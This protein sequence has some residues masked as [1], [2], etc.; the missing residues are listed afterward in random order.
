MPHNPPIKLKELKERGML[1]EEKFFSDLAQEAGV[2]DIEIAQRVYLGLIRLIT[3]RLVESF[4][5]RL[6][7]LGDMAVPLFKARTG[8]VGN[9][10][11]KI[12]PRRT[13]K[14]Y[15]KPDWQKHIAA[16]FGYTDY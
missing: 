12:P 16:K 9:K 1:D 2:H 5:T 10:T 15:P 7:H 6:P 11:V 8:R 13:I 4:G 3:K 14:F